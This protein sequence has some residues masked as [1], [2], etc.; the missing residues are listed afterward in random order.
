MRKSV[1]KA[2]APVLLG[3]LT[4]VL[5]LGPV[6]SVAANECEGEPFLSTKKVYRVGAECYQV[7]LIGEGS[8]SDE[9]YVDDSSARWNLSFN[10]T[11]TRS[12]VCPLENDW[13]DRVMPMP[14]SGCSEEVR[15]YVLDQHASLDAEC[16]VQA[17][18]P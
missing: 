3:G 18:D 11:D 12:F 16:F 13:D 7:T 1:P 17:V 10:P 5:V 8:S 4:I 9:S 2:L 15:I 14:V 6:R